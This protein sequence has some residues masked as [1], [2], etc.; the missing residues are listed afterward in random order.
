MAVNLRPM[1]L[2][3]QNFVDACNFYQHFPPSFYPGFIFSSSF[4]E[5]QQ[6]VLLSFDLCF[7]AVSY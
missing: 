2:K 7:F 3:G 4:N 1:F 5:Y 6:N